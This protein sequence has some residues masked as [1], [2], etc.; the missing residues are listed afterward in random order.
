MVQ[1]KQIKM[2]AATL[3]VGLAVVFVDQFL[4]ME[5]QGADA[6]PDAVVTT[7]AVD[8]PG[9]APEVGARPFS[10]GP[11]LAALLK[12]VSEEH[13][14]DT[15]RVEDAFKPWPARAPT[16]NAV[17]ESRVEEPTFEEL[18]EDFLMQHK[19]TAVMRGNGLTGGYAVVGNQV[20]RIGH[21]LD[22]FT[23]TRVGDNA[24]EFELDGRSLT[25]EVNS[26]DR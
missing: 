24:A 7:P 10:T 22:G 8:T 11:E 15:G 6:A 12:R 2:L 3:A 23:L 25:A 4:L 19:I 18:A 16:E 20:V 21:V 5:P 17:D 9:T 13:A 26:T 14:L 1:P